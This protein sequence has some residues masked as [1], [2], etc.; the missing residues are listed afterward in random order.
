MRPVG[1]YVAFLVVRHLSGRGNGRKR[2]KA[3]PNPSGKRVSYDIAVPLTPDQRAE[4]Q[5]RAR[6]DARS[7][8]SYVARL[9]VEDVGRG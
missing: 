6:D 8:S 2:R 5:A 9:I 3:V 4:L 7:V 1:G